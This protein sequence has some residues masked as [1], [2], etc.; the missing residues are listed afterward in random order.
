[1]RSAR[2]LEV[3][4]RL[5]HRRRALL[6]GL[7][8]V[9]VVLADVRAHAWTLPGPRRWRGGPAARVVSAARPAC[10]RV[11]PRWS[12]GCDPAW[13]S[14][15]A[16]RP[17]S[18]AVPRGP[19]GAGSP[20][21]RRPTWSAARRRPAPRRSGGSSAKTRPPWAS[22]RSR[23]MARPEPGAARRTRRVGPVEAVEDVW[24]RRGR[25]ARSVV[26]DRQQHALPGRPSHQARRWAAR[27]GGQLGPRGR[28]DRRRAGAWVSAL[29]TMLPRIRSSASRS[30]QPKRPAR[31]HRADGLVQAGGPG[32]RPAR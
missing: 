5:G 13:P 9:G 2:P 26:P 29:A 4:Q 11:Y 24:Q 32:W 8:A 23:T 19:P 31:G 12:A 17:R 22:T 6:L 18:S 30:A 7:A 10:A 16:C 25:D 14:D 1:M 20:A 28:C 27:Q 3:R 15:G 21:A